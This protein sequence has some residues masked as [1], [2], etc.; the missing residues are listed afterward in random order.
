MEK[1][2]VVID[3]GGDWSIRF[4]PHDQGRESKWYRVEN[5]TEAEEVHTVPVPGPWE[6]NPR[7][8]GYDGVA[9]YRRRFAIPA[10][11]AGNHIELR[12]ASVNYACTVYLD[13]REIRTHE[14]GY[15]PFHVTLPT[16]AP[17]RTVDLVLRIVDPGMRAIDGFTLDAIPHS[18]ESWY[19]NYGGITGDVTLHVRPRIFV[20][21]LYPILPRPDDVADPRDDE[22]GAEAN[23][24]SG[25][26]NANRFLATLENRLERPVTVRWRFTLSEK[27]S[28][29]PTVSPLEGSRVLPPGRTEIA[30]DLTPDLKLKSWSIGAPFLYRARLEVESEFGAHGMNRTVGARRF[31]LRPEGFY[32]NGAPC[33]LKGVLYQPGWP[34][35]LARPPDTAWIEEEVRDIR[36]AG[37][38]LI[39]CHLRP[40]PPALLSACDAQ[41]LLVMA[42]PA[43]G[44]IRT[45]SEALESRVLAAVESL[46]LNSRHHPSIVWWGLLNELSGVVYPLA[47]RLMARARAL[48]PARL[49]TDDSGGWGGVGRYL[50]PFET[51][52]REYLDYHVYLPYPLSDAATRYL[53]ALGDGRR[54]AF[55]SE[56]GF[57]GMDDLEATV[58]A[59]TGGGRGALEDGTE[60]HAVLR[61]A[62]HTLSATP[63]GRAFG[64]VGELVEAA[65][66]IQAE[67]TEAIGGRIRANPNV[68]G[69]CFT[70]YRDISW[71]LSAGMVH[72]MGKRKPVFH[73][74]RKLNG[75]P[76]MA[77]NRGF[78]RPTSLDV[79]S[80]EPTD[81]RIHLPGDPAEGR[82]LLFRVPEVLVGMIDPRIERMLLD[83]AGNL[84]K[85]TIIDNGSDSIILSGSPLSLRRPENIAPWI[86]LMRYVR[87]GG[88]LVYL[89]PP[90]LDH[91]FPPIF[92][93]YGDEGFVPDLPLQVHYRRA[94]GTFVGLFHYVTPELARIEGNLIDSDEP[95]RTRLLGEGFGEVTPH[96]AYLPVGVDGISVPAG[97]F[98][99]Y[100][101]FV[102]GDVVILPYGR[103]RIYLTTYRWPPTKKSVSDPLD[104]ART[105][106]FRALIDHALRHA[107]SAR[108]NAL[109]MP[110]PEPD[111]ETAEA[112]ARVL[113][114]HRLFLG[115]GERLSIQ[116]LDGTRARY[117]FYGPV[118]DWNRTRIQGLERLLDGDYNEALT[119]LRTLLDRVDD[120]LH[121]WIDLE[122]KLDARLKAHRVASRVDYRLK[123]VG[124]CYHRALRA[125]TGEG[126]AAF[127]H[128]LRWFVQAMD[129]LEPEEAVESPS[130]R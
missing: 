85:E 7:F 72:V 43:I 74:L 104:P 51:E 49:I 25:M 59:F 87:A 52:P 11:A 88:T 123:R 29:R 33:Y 61:E 90:V 66:A 9:W 56:F 112:L 121:E 5:W 47:P 12:F 102:G 118:F 69:Y 95:S 127:D 107:E 58:K 8:A 119:R 46:I 116:R 86:R 111:A 93:D 125:L 27:N 2:E 117:R 122:R 73:A 126:K 6:C 32:L 76:S 24:R 67:A 4:D 83:D 31:E 54:P 35:T 64:S 21:D 101:R 17:G 48:D 60:Y 94:R 34:R 130:K 55:V 39:R 57:G 129:V 53:A 18:K 23:P 71:E 124:R 41:G 16:D 20:R 84:P 128:A 91:A 15:S 14:G 79:E 92:M 96:H 38:N 113:H 45:P 109:D 80:R 3:L 13:G 42:E 28:D 100:G 108:G 75:V 81:L 99:A 22:N 89:A 110:F 50:P 44:W 97:V 114:R 19:Y 120:R 1:D 82:V 40:P 63:L 70:Q 68:A 37:F 36:E 62:R 105:G 30:G 10:S 78:P 115:L 103:G 106:L 98:D 65:N 77:T 26:S